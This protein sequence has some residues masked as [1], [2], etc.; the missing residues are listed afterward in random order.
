MRE[1]C[2]LAA[3]VL[4]MIEPLVLPGVT[5]GEIDRICH[6]YILAHGA[7]P[8]PLGYR[9][10]PKATC[11]SINEVVCHGIPSFERQ[12]KDGDIIN[13]DI[14]TTLHGFHGDTS[15]TFYVGT[16]AARTRHLVETT[17][18]C[19]RRAV[20]VVRPGARVGDIGHAIQTH[21]EGHGCSVVRDFV[22]H[23]LGREFHCAPEVPHFGKPGRGPRLRPG[24]TFTIEPMIN[25][26]DWHIEILEDDWTAVTRDGSLSAQFEHTLLVTER[27]V[28]IMTQPTGRADR[29]QPASP[30]T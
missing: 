23:G 13:I 11:T 3:D 16:P 26:G 24:M 15:K 28:D 6:A 25:L 21:A 8:S 9:G 20:E 30:S 22:G 12:L 18:E 17:R 7:I 19:L 4:V 27:G 2:Q 5:T 1:S 14:T 29:A 10:F